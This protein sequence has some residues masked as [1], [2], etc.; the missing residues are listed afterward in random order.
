MIALAIYVI[1]C[2]L[3]FL[4]SK[5]K[6]VTFFQWLFL[7]IAVAFNTDGQDMEAY[8]TF[9]SYFGQFFQE[10]F[11]SKEILYK[12]LEYLFYQ[13]GFDFVQFNAIL[14]CLLFPILLYFLYK[15]TKFPALAMSLILL[16]PGIDIAIQ[17][18]N[19]AAMLILLLGVHLLINAKYFN[20]VKYVICTIIAGY[21]HT[22]FF[23]YILILFFPN[24]DYKKYKK[25]KKTIVLI[26]VFVIFIVG[27][28]IP[29]LASRVMDVSSYNFYFANEAMQLSLIKKMFFLVLQ[30][31]ITTIFFRSAKML[32]N[33]RMKKWSPIFLYFS[34]LFLP[35]YFYGSNFVRMYRNLLPFYYVMLLNTDYRHIKL[36]GK[37][38]LNFIYV[39]TMV[40][41]NFL[42]FYILGLGWA[43]VAEPIFRDNLVFQWIN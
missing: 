30:L 5:S 40:G 32:E 31:L 21:I 25:Y 39:V 1:L 29:S 3:G 11:D 35:T 4:L 23:L 16:F 14:M 18:R 2:L 6:I 28:I 7:L 37:V 26:S 15:N 38:N 36:S 24:I 34:I 8:R 27:P 20:R 9:Y 17:K 22:S 33:E 41:I 43:D 12:W 13:R 19:T 42:I 10:S